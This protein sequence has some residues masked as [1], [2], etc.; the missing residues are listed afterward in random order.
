MQKLENEETMQIVAEKITLYYNW[1]KLPEYK[2]IKE[3]IE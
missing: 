1:D 3:V 2:I